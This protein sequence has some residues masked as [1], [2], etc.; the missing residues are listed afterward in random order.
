MLPF[1]FAPTL[2]ALA[3]MIGCLML[4]AMM[5]T[6]SVRFIQRSRKPDR[7]HPPARV[8]FDVTSR[9]MM[10]LMT[11]TVLQIAVWA[12]VYH[13][14]ASFADFE[15]ELYFSG[16]TFTSLGYG[17]I[18]LPR[19]LRLLAPLEAATGLLM[20]GITTAVLVAI[21]QYALKPRMP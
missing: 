11:G 10:V 12:L 17:D 4:Q 1:A 14:T 5:V 2:L 18:V 6:G 13:W 21:L 9:A 19:G 16:V 7:H 3:A 20:F 8:I 15:T